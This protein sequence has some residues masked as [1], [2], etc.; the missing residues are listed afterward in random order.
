MMRTYTFNLTN[1]E[2]TVVIE[3]ENFVQARRLLREKLAAEQQ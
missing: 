2:R 1:P 3:A